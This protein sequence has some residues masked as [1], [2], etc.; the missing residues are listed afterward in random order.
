MQHPTEQPISEPHHDLVTEQK[1]L[2]QENMRS[3]LKQPYGKIIFIFPSPPWTENKAIKSCPL[4]DPLSMRDVIS[5]PARTNLS[6]F[7]S[8]ARGR[9]PGRSEPSLSKLSASKAAAQPSAR[10]QPGRAQPRANTEISATPPL[11]PRTTNITLISWTE[12]DPDS[13][14]F[15]VALT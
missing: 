5:P 9:K 6:L 10:L 3:F 7:G 1:T 8:P 12:N 15:I 14:L 4:S 2:Q 11:P 13:Q